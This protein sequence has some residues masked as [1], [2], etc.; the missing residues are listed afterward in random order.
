M[1]RLT[2]SPLR[3]DRPLR[4]EL[5]GGLPV[6]DGASL[7]LSGL[8]EGAELPPGAIDHPRIAGPARRTGGVLHLCLHLPHGLVPAGATPAA[9]MAPA[10]MMVTADGPVAIPRW[11]DVEPEAAAPAAPVAVD[12]DQM[13]TAAEAALAALATARAAARAR[14][15]AHITTARAALITVLPGQDIIYQAKEAEARAWI[16]ATTAEGEPTPTLDDYPLLAA[17]IG[18]TAPDAHSLAQLW[19]N[20]AQL[21]RQAAAELEALRLGVGAAIDAAETVGEVEAALRTLGELT[22]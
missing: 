9:V 17:E 8:P 4:L 3:D 6:I 15:T 21:W 19:L 18:L 12:W 22:V 7:D 1:I 2:F 10:P 16:A 11:P 20:M 5:Q 14:L 13:I